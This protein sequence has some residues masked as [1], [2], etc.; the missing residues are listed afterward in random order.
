[1]EIFQNYDAQEKNTFIFGSTNKLQ[2]SE[3]FY[4]HNGEKQNFDV[5]GLCLILLEL[6]TS[7]E[8]QFTQF[9]NNS[10]PTNTGMAEHPP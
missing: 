2:Y 6:F 5:N 7:L 4:A 8:K 1:M 9:P 3:P 10:V